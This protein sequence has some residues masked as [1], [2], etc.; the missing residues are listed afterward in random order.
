M[1][2]M[3]VRAQFA[4]L[5][6]EE[7]RVEEMR[8]LAS[9]FADACI[10]TT[11]EAMTAEDP[12]LAEQLQRDGLINAEG[13]FDTGS[14]LYTAIAGPITASLATRID[15]LAKGQAD[16]AQFKDGLRRQVQ[17]LIGGFGKKDAPEHPPVKPR[18]I[19]YGRPGEVRP[20]TTPPRE[21]PPESLSDAA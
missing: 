20:G 3:F 15:G 13:T 17:N 10:L 5:L 1:E 11:L 21:S 9:E 16:A 14:R 4:N 18:P 7:A 6:R 8:S 12:A 2:T 19:F